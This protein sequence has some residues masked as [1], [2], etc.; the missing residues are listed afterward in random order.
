MSM[1]EKIACALFGQPRHHYKG[2]KNISKSFND[3]KWDV[4]FFCHSYQA[5]KTEKFYKASP[6]R[7]KAGLSKVI[8]NT[9]S[10]LSKLYNPT[11]IQVDPTYVHSNN[12]IKDSL[13]YNT[14]KHYQKKPAIY[15]NMENTWS[16]IYSRSRVCRLVSESKNNYK[17]VVITRYDHRRQFT[18]ILNKD[19]DFNYI[20]SAPRNSVENPLISD[21]LLITGFENFVKI[22]DVYN[23]LEN[24]KNNKK[25]YELAKELN[26]EFLFN[27]EQLIL[28]NIVYH[29]GNLDILKYD[30]DIPGI[31]M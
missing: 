21:H 31:L 27:V 9:K 13:I 8:E 14:T 12:S 7:P 4:D 11:E 18:K 25:L 24:I 16:Q 23:N 6:W 10:E 2:F 3:S 22:F 30:K 15:D 28:L 26:I 1:K 17:L 19:L 29:F 20:Y 5:D